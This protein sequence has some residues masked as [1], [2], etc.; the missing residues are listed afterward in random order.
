MNSHKEY[1]IQLKALKVVQPVGEFFTAV[2]KPKDLVLIA[3]ADVRRM[4]QRDVERYLGIQREL[5]IPRV[6][7]IQEYVR[8]SD[9]TF[10]TSIILSVNDKCASFDEN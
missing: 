5:S 6:K 9:A 7:K 8:R 2:M 4:D 3:K 10:P 1:T